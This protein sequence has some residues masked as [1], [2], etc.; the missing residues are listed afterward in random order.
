MKPSCADGS[1]L[2]QAPNHPSGSW[3]FP[4][5][6]WGTLADAQHRGLNQKGRTSRAA[7]IARS[8]PSRVGSHGKPRAAPSL[9]ISHHPAGSVASPCPCHRWQSCRRGTAARPGAA[10]TFLPRAHLSAELSAAPVIGP[11]RSLMLGV[12]TAESEK[13][14]AEP[15][16]GASSKA[17]KYQRTRGAG[18]YPASPPSPPA[19]NPEKPPGRML[20]SG[21]RHRRGTGMR[22]AAPGRKHWGPGIK[23]G[24]LV[25]SE[26][27]HGI[28]GDTPGLKLLGGTRRWSRRLVISSRNPPPALAGGKAL[29]SFFF[30]KKMAFCMCQSCPEPGGTRL[31][32]GSS[33][34]ATLRPASPRPPSTPGHL[35]PPPA[36]SPALEGTPRLGGTDPGLRTGP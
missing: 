3:S 34:L 12:N 23:L 21:P 19:V 29:F 7:P 14:R 20:C 36:M 25:A 6:C 13:T 17:A 1:T 27:A 31:K 33:L 15:S 11:R 26:L 2:S 5:G 32:R 22:S 24:C 30:T 10:F 4:S 28:D 35:L 9:G 18:G 8:T 16:L